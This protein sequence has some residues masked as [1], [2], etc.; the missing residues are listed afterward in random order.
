M[1]DLVTNLTAAAGVRVLP[2]NTLIVAT[3]PNLQRRDA[4]GNL[5][6]TY[7]IGGVFNW[8][9]VNL[10]ADG[11]SFWSVGGSPP[12]IA[13]F[14]LET[15]VL[16]AQIPVD[17]INSANSLAVMGEVTAIGGGG[18]VR[19]RLTIVRDGTDVLVSWPESATNYFLEHTLSIGEPATWQSNMIPPAVGGGLKTVRQNANST[20]RYFRLRRP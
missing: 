3:Q 14:N 2:D 17:A 6:R 19:P 20:N 11:V 9:S 12:S 13:R 15:S 10:D 16:L 4:S 18:T 7:S 1:P 5:I 8:T